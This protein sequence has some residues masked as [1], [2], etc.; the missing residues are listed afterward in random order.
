[1]K[2]SAKNRHRSHTVHSCLAVPS[3]YPPPLSLFT[4]RV[5]PAWHVGMAACSGGGGGGGGGDGGGGR[6]FLEGRGDA[7]GN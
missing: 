1:M 3:L 2:G 4:R 7:E 6:A 5:L